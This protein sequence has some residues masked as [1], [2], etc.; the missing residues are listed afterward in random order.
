[1]IFRSIIEG[2]NVIEFFI[3][4]S[5]VII[6]S[7]FYEPLSQYLALLVSFLYFVYVSVDMGRAHSEVFVDLGCGFTSGERLKFS[8]LFALIYIDLNC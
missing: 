7:I 2:H 1:M 6:L 3:I 5:F 4:I 8:S